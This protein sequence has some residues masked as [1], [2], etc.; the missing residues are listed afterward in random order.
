MA[1]PFVRTNGTTPQIDF[2]TPLGGVATLACTD[3]ITNYTIT[4][5]ASDQTVPVG[6]CSANQVLVG[7]GTNTHASS[8]NFTFDGTTLYANAKLNLGAVTNASPVDGDL[9]YDTTRQ[10]FAFTGGVGIGGGLNVGGSITAGV[11]SGAGNVIING[12]ASFVRG[13]QW[14]SCGNLRWQAYTSA[15]PET[16]YNAGSGFA[17]SA[18]S[19][20]G[21]V[22]D[23]PVSIRRRAGSPV[24]I[25]RP[26]NAT[27]ST[28]ST[29]TT[30]GALVV[31]GG[32]GI[33]GT[34]NVGAY[35]KLGAVTNASPA[36]GAFWYD[37]TQKTFASGVNGATSYMSGVI[38]N[39][40]SS[41]TV[42]NTTGA[43]NLLGT[44]IGSATL[45]ANFATVGRSIRVK[46]YGY[47]STGAAN[48]SA[49]LRIYVGPNPI[50]TSTGTLPSGLSNAL[51]EFDF[52]FSLVATGKII[53][54][55]SLKI[56]PSGAFGSSVGMALVMTAPATINATIANALNVTYQWG[57]ASASNTI[58]MTNATIEVLA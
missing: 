17:I 42:A 28:A 21:S 14:Q 13:V 27:D 5:Q 33:G 25:N 12:G 58:T 18:Y 29:S 56:T 46:S 38:F 34:L 9:W 40:T 15:D 51:V 4:F 48:T 49:T 35:L 1:T 8:P 43:T 45:P 47:I 24:D 26:I 6:T 3:S 57:T 7:S 10:T 39:Q 50:L 23:T 11:A 36:S 37:T 19:D 22:I 16:G 44:G 30:T 53:G 52:T 20:N 54:H 31:T 55:G 32:V 41:V 2:G